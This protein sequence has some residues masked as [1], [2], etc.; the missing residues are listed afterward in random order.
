MSTKTICDGCGTEIK[1][2]KPGSP[3]TDGLKRALTIQTGNNRMDWDLCDGC[4]GRVADALV[5]L[6]PHTP[7]DAWFQLIRPQKQDR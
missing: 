6:L 1:H 7:R 4:Q 3:T 5:E 2:W